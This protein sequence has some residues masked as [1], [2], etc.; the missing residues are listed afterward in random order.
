MKQW[1]IPHLIPPQPIPPSIS[2]HLIVPNN[3]R[4]LFEAEFGI[5]E[6]NDG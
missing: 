3:K 5:V 4:L 1:S 2:N 6:N